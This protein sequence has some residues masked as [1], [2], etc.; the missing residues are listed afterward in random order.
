MKNNAWDFG[1]SHNQQVRMNEIKSLVNND[2]G[3]SNKNFK[4]LFQCTLNHFVKSSFPQAFKNQKKQKT[5]WNNAESFDDSYVADARDL[6]AREARFAT[7]LTPAKASSIKWE[8]TRPLLQDVDLGFGADEEELAE[9]TVNFSVVGRCQKLE[10][11]YLRLTS[12]PDPNEVRPE[13][14]LKAAFDMV[15]TK[16]E[17]GEKDWKYGFFIDIV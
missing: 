3:L 16:K 6:K 1:L 8:P 13:G 14:V 4:T 7:V 9:A 15:V 11:P 12:A 2:L 10:K 5:S 17:S